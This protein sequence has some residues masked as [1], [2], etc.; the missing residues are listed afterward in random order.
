MVFSKEEGLRL[1]AC[2]TEI[3]RRQKI[4]FMGNGSWVWRNIPLVPALRR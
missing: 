4:P 2:P 1:Q 3:E